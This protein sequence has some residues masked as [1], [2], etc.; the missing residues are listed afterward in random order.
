MTTASFLIKRSHKACPVAG[1]N[2]VNRK[3]E[4]AQG[5]IDSHPD[6]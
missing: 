1:R 5:M 2:E 4:K 3:Q 6:S